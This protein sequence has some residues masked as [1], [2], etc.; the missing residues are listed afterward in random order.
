MR[1]A[2]QLESD[3]GAGTLKVGDRLPSER[4]IAE[5]LGA[6]RMTARHALKLLERRGLV[7]TRTGLGAFV[8]ERRIEKQLW[9]L[10]G[11]TEEMRRTGRK[12]SSLV[13]DA[14]AGT[15]DQ[16]TATALTVSESSPVHRLVRVRLVDSTPVA[17]E[18]TEIPIV[19][20]PG[21]LEK[22]DFTTD[23]LYRVLRDEYGL[24]P[25]GAEESVLAATPD[26]ATAA[27]LGI[28]A[29]QPV[30]RFTRLT[31]ER[32][33]RPFEYVRSAYRGDCFTMRVRLGLTNGK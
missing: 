30:L 13:L 26:A 10:T 12:I 25:T 22:T 11:F 9:T 17:I 2:R 24:A 21:L 4:R 15:A 32:N 5:E 6:S 18:R 20:A 7:E 31:F 3:I 8:A 23:S 33:G 1:I 29:T 27:A 19:L 14:G 28:A 16:E